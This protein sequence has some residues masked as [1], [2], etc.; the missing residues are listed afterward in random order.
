MLS[1]LRFQIDEYFNELKKKI[2]IKTLQLLVDSDKAECLVEQME[3]RISVNQALIIET[4]ESL[5]E[6]N[7]MS[8]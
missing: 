7:L 2:D 8:L 5:R 1:L 4:V 6:N 3:K